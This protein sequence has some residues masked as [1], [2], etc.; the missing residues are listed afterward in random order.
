M[1]VLFDCLTNIIK[2]RDEVF[3]TN[4]ETPSPNKNNYAE[5]SQDLQTIGLVKSQQLLVLPF[6]GHP[7]AYEPE[8]RFFAMIFAFSYFI[9][10]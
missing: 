8:G 9:I 7:A 5:R 1:Y 4:Q 3:L 10:K 2:K 6:A